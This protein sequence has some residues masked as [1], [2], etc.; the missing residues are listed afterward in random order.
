MQFSEWK[1]DCPWVLEKNFLVLFEFVANPMAKLHHRIRVKSLWLRKCILW[2]WKIWKIHLTI[3]SIPIAGRPN[4]SGP[5]PIL[6]TTRDLTL[7]CLEKH[8]LV[9]DCFCRILIAL[10]KV[11][12]TTNDMNSAVRS[13]SSNVITTSDATLSCYDDNEIE[14]KN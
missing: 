14:L 12:D 10:F 7:V 8:F 2:L 6:C 3:L 11:P 4:T 13:K 9:C 5:W 1:L